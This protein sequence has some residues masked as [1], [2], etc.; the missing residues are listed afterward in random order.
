MTDMMITHDGGGYDETEVTPEPY[1][2]YR[3]SVAIEQN[4]LPLATVLRQMAHAWNDDRA[5]LERWRNYCAGQEPP[6]GETWPD[7]AADAHNDWKRLAAL[8]QEMYDPTPCRLD[9][10][11]LCQEHFL[12]EP[13]CIMRRIEN[14]IWVL[15]QP[16]AGDGGREGG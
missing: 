16:D 3:L 9:Q 12:S 15:A 11:G 13:P 6:D 2:L 7:V 4:G 8:L 5:D 1:S 10:H 14:E